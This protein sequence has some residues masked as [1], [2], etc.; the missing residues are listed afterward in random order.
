MLNTEKSAINLENRPLFTYRH[1]RV[2]VQ[3]VGENLRPENMIA[4]CVQYI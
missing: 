1:V 2:R 3:T 4:T